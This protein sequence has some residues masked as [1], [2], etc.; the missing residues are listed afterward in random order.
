MDHRT[1]ILRHV[2][3]VVSI[4][5]VACLANAQ[6]AKDRDKPRA[7]DNFRSR[8]F[9]IH[10]DLPADDA[11]ELLQK[12]ETMLQIISRYWGAPSRKQIECY[13]IDDVQYWPPG[14]L[15][16]VAADA[17]RGGGITI[18][19]GIRRGNQLN[20]NAIVYASN[21]F[22]TPQ[23][24]AVHAYCYQTFGVTG[25]TWYAEGMAEM[26]NYWVDGNSSVAAPDYVIQF[27][28][29][30]KRKSIAEITDNRQ[31]TGDGWQNYAWRWALCHFLVNNRNYSDRFRTIGVGYLTGKPA[32]FERAFESKMEEL[33][34][35]FE[36]FIDHLEQGFDVSGCTWN[37]KARFRE[38]KGTRP[39]VA[40]IKADKGWQPGGLKV[41]KGKTY[42]YTTDGEWNT[43]DEADDVSATGHDDGTGALIGAIYDDHALSAE[44]VFD[45]DGVFTAIKDGQLMLRC[46]DKWNQLSDNDG[47]I[48]VDFM[49]TS[50]E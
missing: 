32:S 38:H 33:E 28:K 13:V 48:I 36:F 27:L 10:T 25:P 11:H 6:D 37:W 29:R 2:F 18:A 24:E 15:S 45:S 23:H 50:S 5:V 17:V 39:V 30:S 1:R 22:G 3:F 26:G 40:K 8:N 46:R 14:L 20:M 34:F 19:R 35:E 42:H 4:F 43:S 49:S 7:P 47:T 21:R 31:Q 41:T 9:L 12:M 44:F 16:N